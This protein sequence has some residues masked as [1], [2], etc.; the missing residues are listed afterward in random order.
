MHS[1]EKIHQVKNN[2]LI[3]Q[4]SKKTANQKAVEQERKKLNA[5]I[6][7]S[8]NAILLATARLQ[9][10]TQDINKIKTELLREGKMIQQ[11]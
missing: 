3:L 9:A 1:I 6:E 11:Q 2:L 8:Q 5:Q 4:N 7:S 10:A